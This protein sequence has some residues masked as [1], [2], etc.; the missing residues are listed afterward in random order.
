MK[1]LF[2]YLFGIATA[3]YMFVL[4]FNA[5]AF[6]LLS[7]Y[8]INILKQHGDILFYVNMTITAIQI[9]FCVTVINNFFCK[10]TKEDENEELTKNENQYE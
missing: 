8:Y 6:E 7:D 4:L 9:L 1:A 2:Y 5:Y 3:L 10:L